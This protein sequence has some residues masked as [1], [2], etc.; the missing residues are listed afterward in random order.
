M[1]WGIK[2][3]EFNRRL[4]GSTQMEKTSNPISVF[5]SADTDNSLALRLGFF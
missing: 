1:G 3:W 4:L 5:Y 2:G